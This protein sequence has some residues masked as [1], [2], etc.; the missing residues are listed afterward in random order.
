MGTRCLT[1]TTPISREYWWHRRACWVPITV[2][3]PC[4]NGALDSGCL[5]SVRW[6][7]MAGSC[8]P[9]LQGFSAERF[10]F[11]NFYTMGWLFWDTVCSVRLKVLYC[12]GMG[13][14]VLCVPFSFGREDCCAAFNFQM[15]S[16]SSSAFLTTS[17]AEQETYVSPYWGFGSKFD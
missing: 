16:K 5:P 12:V 6:S 17:T 8:S 10:I 1:H 15:C 4:F 2:L 7:A 14:S 13:L 11:K 9:A 3:V